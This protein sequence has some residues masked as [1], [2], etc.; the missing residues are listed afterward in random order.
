MNRYQLAI[1]KVRGVE[2]PKMILY[3]ND[4][5]MKEASALA[6]IVSMDDWMEIRNKNLPIDK[7][8]RKI[9]KQVRAQELKDARVADPRVTEFTPTPTRVNFSFSEA[10][11]TMSIND[12]TERYEAVTDPQTTMSHVLRQ[13][14]ALEQQRRQQ[15]SGNRT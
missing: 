12:F 7:Y 9:R 13:R 5:T 11:L 10:D 4:L 15:Y 6:E 1:C 2:P 8:R 3:V 14:E